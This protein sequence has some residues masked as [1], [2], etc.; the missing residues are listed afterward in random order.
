[1]HGTSCA[2]R[3]YGEYLELLGVSQLLPASAKGLAN[4]TEREGGVVLHD[5]G[6]NLLA[7]VHVAAQR[8]GISKNDQGTV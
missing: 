4:I 3:G 2:T 1:M 7:V 8:H 6:A 5:L